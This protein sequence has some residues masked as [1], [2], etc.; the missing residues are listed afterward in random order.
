M[1]TQLDYYIENQN[2]LVS[3][4]NNQI[5][6]VKD[7]KHMGTFNSKTEA[8]RHMQAEG[9]VPGTFMIILCTPGDEQYTAWFPPYVTFDQVKLN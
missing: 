5:I 2:E 9:H 8:L 6:A 1:P 7:G 4:H 3:K